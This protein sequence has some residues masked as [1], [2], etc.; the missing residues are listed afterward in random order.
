MAK[1]SAGLYNLMYAL[2]TRNFDVYFCLPCLYH[3]LF[4]FFFPVNLRTAI[5]G[6]VFIFVFADFFFPPGS[7]YP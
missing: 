3:V 1:R 7:D 2:S 6:S 4:R 5:F